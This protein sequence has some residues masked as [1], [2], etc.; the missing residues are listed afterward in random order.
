[1]ARLPNLDINLPEWKPADFSR[2]NKEIEKL[3]SLA[4]SA[5]KGS[6]SFKEAC[7]EFLRLKVSGQDHR[8]PD[9]IKKPIDVRA[10]TYLLLRSKEFSSFKFDENF[11]RKLTQ[12]RNPISRLSLLQLVEI[13]FKRFDELASSANFDQLCKLLK[14]QL[15]HSAE[16][17]SDLGKMAEYKEVLFDRS[18]PTSVV[19]WAKNQNYD[20]DV[21]FRR[22][23][24]EGFGR[25]RFLEI[26]RYT[27]YLETLKSIPVGSDAPVLAEVCKK[28]VYL[29]PGAD[30][31]LLGHEVLSV[32]IDRSEVSGISDE[33]QSVLLSIAGDPRVP[34]SHPRYQQWW[35]LLGDTRIS[36]V[37]GW[38][39]RFDLNLF[40]R[41]LE[42]YG[43][44][45][46]N[47]D[48][49][50]MFPSRRR[51]L[52]GLL[53]QK[54]VS[55]SRLF[56]SRHADKYVRNNYDK[57]EI[58]DYATVSD[59]NISMIYLQI[60]DLHIVEGTHSFKIWIYPAL[61]RSANLLNYGVKHFT[62]HQI[63]QGLN[64]RYIREY[65]KGS[66]STAITH[67]PKN[68]LWQYKAIR[69]LQSYGID[70]DVE[71]LFSREDYRLYK[72]LYGISGYHGSI[73][74][75]PSALSVEIEP[76][77]PAY[78][79]DWPNNAPSNR[80]PLERASLK[81]EVA[82]RSAT[83][84]T[85]TAFME[86]LNIGSTYFAG[87]PEPTETK[88]VNPAA[89]EEVKSVLKGL[90]YL[91]IQEIISRTSLS[92]EEVKE[93]LFSEEG[94]VFG[95]GKG[96]WYLLEN[97]LDQAPERKLDDVIQKASKAQQRRRQVKPR[98]YA[99]RG[100]QA[101]STDAENIKTE[102]GLGAPDDPEATQILTLLQEQ[103]GLTVEQIYQRTF[104]THEQVSTQLIRGSNKWFE[105]SSGIWFARKE[106][107]HPKNE[108]SS[109]MK[110]CSGC[111]VVKPLQSFYKS[112]KNKDGYTKWCK[113]CLNKT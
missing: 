110:V 71:S 52:E 87:K 9:C 62:R 107:A 102:V 90:N 53:E 19:Q 27:Y 86:G 20:L 55:V 83:E 37:K 43:E 97:R 49:K 89:L 101:D 60:G 11:L 109:N 56:L 47:S 45:S 63:S 67:A 94:N 99:K 44:E 91:S 79:P 96:G 111:D 42:S 18:G 95:A 23:G 57:N 14:E 8:I 46:G 112:K 103:P 39:S 31:K 92:R 50:R 5:G 66:P 113:E 13:F 61:A 75:I 73:N 68:C 98:V 70:L 28:E 7:R 64:Q 36:K 72:K 105:C 33:W 51:F 74:T 85:D 32:L 48:L 76:E 82:A 40:L 80:A 69:Y 6:D 3:Q 81:G 106:R 108:S 15:K 93:V 2:L 25:G 16:G 77:E 38:L 84:V 21:C 1:M 24:I 29:A 58:P 59:P 65:G 4:K 88:E 17:E 54:L 22:F 10:V 35:A 41:V 100:R 104:L 34:Q 12:P 26:C 78:Q 30:G